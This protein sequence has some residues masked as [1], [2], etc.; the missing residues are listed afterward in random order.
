MKRILLLASALLVSACVYD[1]TIGAYGVP[2]PV[3][4]GG[5]GYAD[6]GYA[7]PPVAYGYPAYGAPLIGGLVVGG[8]GC[9]WGGYRG[10]YGYRG[11]AGFV[12]PR[13]GGFVGPRGGVVVASG[14][15]L[16]PYR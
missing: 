6:P 7:P 4:A 12:G 5:P 15:G 8:G 3:Y 2:G 13:G 11:G 10:G 16:H 1:P 14:R 9:C